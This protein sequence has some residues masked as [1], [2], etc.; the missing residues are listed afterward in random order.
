MFVL[1]AWSVPKSWERVIIGNQKDRNLLNPL[2]YY[3]IGILIFAVPIQ[4]SNHRRFQSSL[5]DYKQIQI[6][7]YFP[8]MA[9]ITRIMDRKQK[10]ENK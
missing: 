5:T 1:L 10:S 8:S 7:N 4:S 3:Q 6:G 2:K 9:N